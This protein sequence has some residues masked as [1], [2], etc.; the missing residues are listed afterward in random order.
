MHFVSWILIYFETFLSL[1]L[2]DSCMECSSKRGLWVLSPSWPHKRLHLL[3]QQKPRSL[4]NRWSHEE[5]WGKLTKGAHSSCK[6]KALSIQGKQDAPSVIIPCC[7]FP[8]LLI[9]PNVLAPETTWESSRTGPETS[10]L[11]SALSCSSI[12]TRC[13]FYHL[14][15]TQGSPWS[16]HGEWKRSSKSKLPIASNECVVCFTHFSRKIPVCFENNTAVMALNARVEV[17]YWSAH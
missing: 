11:L 16:V 3:S 12:L 5:Q 10:F 1:C 4:L 15:T 7:I 2:L 8:S 6:P 13:M 14:H 9:S 17:K